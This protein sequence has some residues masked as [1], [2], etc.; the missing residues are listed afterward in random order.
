MI[1]N[2]VRPRNF[3]EV[4][5][6]TLIV[7]NIRNQSKRDQFFPVIILCGQYGSG[8]TTMA[9]IIAMAANCEQKDANGNPCGTCD[10]CRAVLE[11]STD[12]IIEIDGASNNGVEEVRKLLAQATTLGIFK[13]KIIVIDEAHML[14]RNA[15]NALLIT[16]ENPPSHCIFILCTTDKD[17]L[18]NTVISRAPVF[19]F[20]KIPDQIIRDHIIEVA[21]QNE[22]AITGDAAGL[23]ARYADGA[24][25]NALQ[26][27][28]QMA[29]QKK[30]GAITEQDV[31][32]VLGLSSIEQRGDFLEACLAG[33]VK[34]LCSSLQECESQ[35]MALKTFVN[36]SLPMATDL[37]LL[38]AGSHVVGS[39]YYLEILKHLS[40]YGERE[41]GKLCRLL[42]KMTGDLSKERIVI[43]ALTVFRQEQVRS[44]TIYPEEDII[45][46]RVAVPAES[47]PE[48]DQKGK[49]KPDF[50]SGFERVQEEMIP[51]EEPKTNDPEISLDDEMSGFGSIF[52]FGNLG[53]FTGLESSKR[54]AKGSDLKK[55]PSS[56]DLLSE[57]SAETESLPNANARKEKEAGP[58]KDVMHADFDAAFTD[59]HQEKDSAEEDAA[60]EEE[61]LSWEEMAQK[62]LV[63]SEV[64]FPTSGTAD[65]VYEELSI[66]RAQQQ[67]EME[68]TVPNQL[69]EE[70]ETNILSPHTR[71]DLIDANHELE[72]LLKNPGFKM[73][74]QNAKVVNKDYQIYLVYD[75]KRYC[76]ASEAFT[77]KK[78]GVHSVMAGDI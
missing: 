63:P 71:A 33:D 20:G 53:G 35:G 68:N 56:V 30:D 62:G 75:M 11:H 34:G 51:F 16:L 21:E 69:E 72:V 46:N 10:S 76:I 4:K 27:L 48:E 65:R 49:E 42:S 7:E 15:F 43:D 54:K 77:L 31:I 66:R 25:R 61:V 17:A 73:V 3:D 59:G 18:P 14:T 5:G 24:M 41:A 13:H 47:A 45:R 44:T 28:E 19:T 55:M 23:L 36:D 52:E 2:E 58:E 57:A 64:T 60:N 40:A 38:L 74:F 50:S 9:R 78:K 26:M 29:M 32:R 70:V 12:G 1:Y 22:I 37:L 8:K 6:Q 67:S 39:T